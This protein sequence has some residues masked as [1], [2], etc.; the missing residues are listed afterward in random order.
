MHIRPLILAGLSILMTTGCARLSSA[1]AQ[2]SGLSTAE[3]VD[4]DVPPSVQRRSAPRRP[5]RVQSSSAVEPMAVLN[6]SIAA[7]QN[8][9]PQNVAGLEN[10]R[11]L[12]RNDPGKGEIL[13]GSI[14]GADAESR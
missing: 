9:K 6:A 14:K 4:D 12:I 2:Y 3:V 5:T 10:I 1:P 8:W 11:P 7:R 13:T